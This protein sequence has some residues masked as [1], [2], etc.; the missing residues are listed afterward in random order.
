MKISIALATYNGGKYLQEQ[1]DSF[2]VQTRLP[3]E[4]VVCDDGSTDNTL[5]IL[6]K[7]ENQ[8]PFT[9][10]I[11]QN[12]QNLG[13]VQ[14]FAKAMSLCSGDIIFLSDQ[15]DAWYSNKIEVITGEF[16]RDQSCMVITSNSDITDESLKKTGLTLLGQLRNVGS[17]ERQFT[18]G[19]GTAIKKVFLKIVLPIPLNIPNGHDGWV[20]E[21]GYLIEGRKIITDVLQ[22]YRRHSDTTTSSIYASFKKVS[23]YDEFWK[24]QGVNPIT[25]YLR[26]MDKLNLISDRLVQERVFIENV[27]T[28]GFDIEGKLISIRNELIAISRR[29]DSLGKSRFARPWFVI[30]NFV[31]GDYAFFNGWKSLV[32]DLL[33]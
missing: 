24:Y 11:F 10:R 26:E 19:C 16:E 22:L 25:G 5:D 15:D 29:V 1:L 13:Y 17:S 12:P 23:W 30:V 3:D 27:T 20:H 2:A 9:V 32:K 28:P 21:L 18:N 14:N 7:Y 4:L 31:Q 8:A 6:R 33:R